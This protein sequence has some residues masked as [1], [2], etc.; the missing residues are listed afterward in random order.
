M[1]NYV[2]FDSEEKFV[3]IIICDE[4]DILPDGHTKQLIP[5]NHYWDQE[6]QQIVRNIHAPVVIESI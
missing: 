6:T 1:P 3:N 4:W 2:V 5:E